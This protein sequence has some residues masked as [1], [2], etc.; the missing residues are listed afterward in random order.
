MRRGACGP[1]AACLLATF[2][3]GCYETS[4]GDGGEEADVAGETRDEAAGDEAAAD[5]AAADDAGGAV[6][7]GAATCAAD[8]VCVHPCC[9]GFDAGGPPCDAGA[10]H[11]LAV[12]A[13]CGAAPTCACFTSDP[14]GIGHCTLITDR[15]VTCLCG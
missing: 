7:C 15:Q 4:P 1:V 14:C 11:C 2:V 5:E 10:P 8:Q 12:P 13:G 3:C 9:G 6:P